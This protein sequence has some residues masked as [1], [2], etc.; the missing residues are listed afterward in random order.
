MFYFDNIKYQLPF[1][2]VDMN[3]TTLLGLQ[4][5]R[6]LKLIKEVNSVNASGDFF[7]D[8]SDVF[9]GLGCISGKHTIRT[10]PSVK[11]VVHHARKF[12]FS[13]QEKL[14]AELQRMT[15]N[16]IIA[17]VDIPTP[18][19][20]SI[21][22]VHKKDGTIRPC[23]DPKDLNR[24]IL[25]EHYSIP[26]RDELLSNLTGSCYF[27]KLDAAN[28]FWQIKLDEESSY[29]TTFNTPFGR[30]RFLVLPFGI[31]SAPEVFHKSVRHIFEHLPGVVT[32]M[33]DILV[34]GKTK[35]EHDERVANVLRACR[36]ANLKL[37]K[38]KATISKWLKNKGDI[39]SADG[40]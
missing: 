1:V 27:S 9:T 7:T 2:I 24:A 20:N 15:N 19:V 14:K 23:L 32:S 16:S 31:S 36:E 8:F 39:I 25:R 29:L 6:K 12:A 5:C 3:A 18:W 22:V 17:P 28:G 33:D 34:H 35:K 38:S 40:L 4:A 30:Y 26:T 10:D 13:T 21:T 37:N 11:P